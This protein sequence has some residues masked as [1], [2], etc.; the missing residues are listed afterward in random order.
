MKKTRISTHEMVLC[1]MF[2]ALMAVGAFIKIMLPIGPFAVTFSLQFFFALLA[3]FIL[4]S[5]LGG[6]SV[7]VYLIVGLCG[8]PIFAHGGGPAYLL[9]PTFGFLIG[10]AAAAFVTG[11]IME[12]FR[13]SDYK[14][15]LFAAFCGEMVYYLCG[16]VYYY[17]MF[18][19]LVNTDG[20]SI[21]VV[22]LI[23]VWF[24]STVVPDFVLC[25]LASLVAVKLKKILKNT[26]L[27][28][29]RLA[30]NK[31]MGR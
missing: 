8:I 19:F 21:G 10:F 4:G 23:Q 26:D 15:F 28:P 6:L 7:T 17:I 30:N 24:L 1:A 22:E 14:T 25:V 29:D 5:F 20:A 18:N 2:V 16:L 9:K 3:G 31:P 12:K 11:L 27:L 13:S